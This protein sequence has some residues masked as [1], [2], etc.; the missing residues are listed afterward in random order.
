[1]MNATIAIQS[2]AR[3]TIKQSTLL[4]FLI[5]IAYITTILVLMLFHE[6]WFDEA[7]SWLIARDSSY[8]ELLA[9][10]PHYEGHPPLW[11]LLLSIPAKLG[12]PYELGI[13]S[14]QLIGASMLGGWFIFRAPMR[15]SAIILMPFTYFFCFQ[16]GV[17]ARPYAF[18]CTLMLVIAHYWKSRTTKPVRLVVALIGLCL[19]SAYGIALA[20]GFAIIWLFETLHMAY[21]TATNTTNSRAT[22]HTMAQRLYHCIIAIPR[23]QFFCLLALAV[24]GI[25]CLICIWPYADAF[26]ARPTLDG[27]STIVQVLIFLLVLPCESMFTS[28]TGD[29]SVRMMTINI[30]AT[31]VCV[32][33]SLIMWATLYRLAA[34]RQQQATLIVPYLTFAAVASQY[35]T[36]HH[37]GLIFMFFVAQW[38]IQVHQQPISREDV[39]AFLHRKI[40]NNLFGCN[41][42]LLTHAVIVLMLLP[43]LWWNISAAIN[44]IRFDF[45]GSRTVAHFI[46]A[47]RLETKRWVTGWLHKKATYDQQGNIRT[48]EFNDTHQYTWQLITANPYFAHN[49]IDCAYQN[50]TFITNQSP[51]EAQMRQELSQCAAKGEP[52][53]FITDNTQAP[54][55]FQ[56]LDYDLS[57]YRSYVVAHVRSSWKSSLSDTPIT[58][59]EKIRQ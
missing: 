14:I 58:V 2:R 46:A 13:K 26:G 45:S 47:N 53:F 52:D 35:F 40:N 36:L 29:V 55:Y 21:T 5:F 49:L 20:A 41:L 3:H 27:N 59:Y 33:V 32:F 44:D 16:Y 7:Q 4:R 17:T 34:R 11:T 22:T 28:F 42:N 30:P 50:R 24:V 9:L 15:M 19:L 1:M 48:P 39:P 10:R 6:P 51:S 12:I 43:S 57:H 38:W 37:V 18:M 23:S 54:Y 31:I 56:H 25:A 8:G